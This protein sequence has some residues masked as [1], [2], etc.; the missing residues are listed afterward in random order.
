MRPK[1]LKVCILMTLLFTCL[2]G[3]Q[4]V[5]DSLYP[6]ETVLTPNLGATQV[7]GVESTA[8]S[9]PEAPAAATPSAVPL[10]TL[11]PPTPTAE[12]L[13]ILP[14]SF[15]IDPLTG[16]EVE[17]LTILDRRPLL[18]KI[19]NFPRSGRPHAG[20]SFADIVFEY[21][22]GL[23][24]NRFMGIFFSQDSPQIGPLR[25]GRLV[26]AQIA[27]MYGAILTYGNADPQ[28]DQILIEELGDRLISPNTA[29]CPA[30]CGVDTHSIA[31]VFANSAELT[32]HAIQAGINNQRPELNGISFDPKPPDSPLIGSFLAVDFS[33]Q[34]EYNR[35]EWVYDPQTGMYNRWIENPTTSGYEMI[36]LIDRVNNAPIRFSNLVIL[37]A[38]YEEYA[39]T[40]HNI[41]IRS[42]EFGQRAVFFRD[43]VVVEGLWQSVDADQ[44]IRFFDNNNVPMNFKPGRTWIVIAGVSSGL[45]QVEAEK[46]EMHFAL[47]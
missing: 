20:L 30:I 2:S 6:V 26:D 28:V 10:D 42:N 9:V 11:I 37:F 15:N 23:G 45:E 21:Y 40:L 31:G 25:S 22:I 38:R 1:S 5:V 29:G 47:P 32:R 18:V 19:S 16:L 27:R 46:W 36:P 4:A 8:I 12:M 7:E 41:H 3:C 44:P 17:D 39:P 34:G 14:A 43:G 33:S 13:E 24:M 35:G